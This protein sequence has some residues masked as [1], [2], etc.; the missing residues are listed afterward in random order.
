MLPLEKVSTP[1]IFG[2]LALH[3]RLVAD[4]MWDGKG[5]VADF[6]WDGKEHDECIHCVLDIG[7]F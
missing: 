5:L 7:Q 2:V 1:G 4:F 6:I 3:Y